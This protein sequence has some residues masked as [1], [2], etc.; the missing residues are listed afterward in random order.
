MRIL[1]IDD[2]AA[3]LTA[4]GSTGVGQVR[5]HHGEGPAGMNV[6]R[7][8]PGGRIGHHP[9]VLPQ[10]LIAVKGDG[11]VRGGEDVWTPLTA[12]RAAY[13][14]PGEPHETWAPHGMTVVVAEARD[15]HPKGLLA[16]AAEAAP[17]GRSAVRIVCADQDGRILMLCWRDPHDGSPLWEPPGGGIEPGEAP[18]QTARRE[19][20]EETGIRG[21]RMADEYV[22]VH[23]RVWWRGILNVADEAFVAARV[24]AE[25][26]LDFSRQTDEERATFVEYRWVPRSGLAGLPGRL[27]PP[28]LPDVTKRLHGM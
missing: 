9:A 5:L 1:A 11:W 26:A 27:E 13:W 4:F 20:D 17:H 28:Q 22:F 7:L 15:P 16:L 21:A 25:P 6:M 12:G 2:Y 18:L 19:L 8:A 23:R 10:L 3:E 14:G 24:A